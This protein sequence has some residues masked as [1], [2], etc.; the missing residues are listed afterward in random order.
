[1]VN[2]KKNAAPAAPNLQ[3]FILLSLDNFIR[4]FFVSNIHDFTEKLQNLRKN[5]PNIRKIVFFHPFAKFYIL[6]YA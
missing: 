6:L 1:M 4:L 5:D 2:I 3:L